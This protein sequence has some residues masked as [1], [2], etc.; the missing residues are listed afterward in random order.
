MMPD[1]SAD[2]R[3][4]ELLRQTVHAEQP[5]PPQN[6]PLLDL[7]SALD[8]LRETL[9]EAVHHA[10]ALGLKQGKEL[11]A[12][13]DTFEQLHP[14]FARHIRQRAIC[15]DRA[16]LGFCGG[17]SAG[18][19]TLLNLLV[20]PKDDFPLP[21]K[22]TRDTALPVFLL[23]STRERVWIENHQGRGYLDGKIEDLA[24]FRHAEGTTFEP[25]AYLVR[26]LYLLA[27]RIDHSD[28]VYLDLPGHTAG[29]DDLRI[30]LDAARQCDAIAYLVDVSQGDLKV[31]DVDFLRALAGVLPPFLILLTKCDKLPPRKLAQAHEQIG[32]TLREQKIPH[33]GPHQWSKDASLVSQHRAGIKAVRD[34]GAKLAKRSKDQRFDEIASVAARLAEICADMAHQ[35]RQRTGEMLD[36]FKELTGSP[37]SPGTLK[38]ATEIL[39]GSRTVGNFVESGFFGKSFSSGPFRE[40][41]YTQANEWLESAQRSFPGYLNA[42]ALYGLYATLADGIDQ[43]GWY[44][45]LNQSSPST[46]SDQWY[47]EHLK[48]IST[49]QQAVIEEIGGIAGKYERANQHRISAARSL[50]ERAT[51]LKKRLA[52]AYW[53]VKTK[54]AEST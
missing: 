23:S 44:A 32:A 39:A 1:V 49:V 47:Y 25:W 19:S 28:V 53:T 41:H 6:E 48:R 24:L 35:L 27:P 20:G 3:L 33:E 36:Q 45:A 8:E 34:Y 42:L 12:L 29:A 16:V 14:N 5:L 13:R 9:A 43:S 18:K 52:Q 2:Q 38:K 4:S 15:G 40:H 17:F 7:G 46:E 11:A 50:S 10:T 37:L 22:A 54:T 31:T 26:S 51:A 21:T 30:A